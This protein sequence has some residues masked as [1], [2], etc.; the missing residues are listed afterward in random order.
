[1][2]L[3]ASV[4]GGNGSRC[5]KGPASQREAGFSSLSAPLQG[6]ETLGAPQNAAG[7]INPLHRDRAG[8]GSWT[9][10]PRMDRA[11]P[12]MRGMG[13]VW[14]RHGVQAALRLGSTDDDIWV[15]LILWYPLLVNK[16]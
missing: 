11:L 10:L 7:E 4:W 16:N 9:R 6:S 13:R 5:R 2:F 3:A 8:E 14:H 15:W 1:M 12:E